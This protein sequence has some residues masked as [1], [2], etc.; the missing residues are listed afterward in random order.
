MMVAE[1]L[2]RLNAIK[3]VVSGLANFVAAAGFAKKH[4]G[5]RRSAAGRRPPVTPLPRYPAPNAA[6]TAIAPDLSE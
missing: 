3:N 1:T 2:A 4:P 6:V 5:G